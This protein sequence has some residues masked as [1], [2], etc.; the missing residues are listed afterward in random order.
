MSDN[1][2]CG[3]CH[4]QI[5]DADGNPRKSVP[6]SCLSCKKSLHSYVICSAVHQPREGAYFC[7]A[8]CEAALGK[9]RDESDSESGGAD[10][11]SEAVHENSV[12]DDA[13]VDSVTEIVN[14]VDGDREGPPNLDDSD[15]S[16]ACDAS[17]LVNG[18]ASN[19]DT[20]SG[21]NCNNGSETTPPLNPPPDEL[22]EEGQRIRMAFQQTAGDAIGLWWGGTVGPTMNAAAST[23]V[24]S[25][26]DG[27]LAIHSKSELIELFRMGKYERMPD[28][29][30][31]HGLVRSMHSDRMALGLSPFRVAKKVFYVGVLLGDGVS[32]LCK[33]PLYE[34]HILCA[35]MRGMRQ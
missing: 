2:V 14:V 9:D 16:G 3:A 17:S 20:Q 35:S 34:A 25:F 27:D 6:H 8:S 5:V 19:T 23:V 33:H 1:L 11:I 22:F 18:N 7:S 10:D 15:Q 24:L 12:A 31:Q 4:A 26:D 32:Q 13:V 29:M 21:D 30:R 28:D